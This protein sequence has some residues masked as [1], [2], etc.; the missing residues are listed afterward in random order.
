MY[1]SVADPD[2]ELRRGPGFILL[3]QLAFLPSVISSFFTQNKRGAQA[4]R[5]PPLDP[6]LLII[7]VCCTVNKD[8]E[9]LSFNLFPFIAL[10]D[11]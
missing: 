4:P 9:D 2:F 6:P 8:M 1:L 10:V 5:A 3:A 7:Q 11:I